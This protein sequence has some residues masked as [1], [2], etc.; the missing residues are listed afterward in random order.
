MF[1]A[2]LGLPVI[3][4]GFVLLHGGVVEQPRTKAF[5]AAGQHLDD[6]VVRRICVPFPSAGHAASSTASSTNRAAGSA[7]TGFNFSI[8][9][10]RSSTDHNFGITPRTPS[11]SSALCSFIRRS[12]ITLRVAFRA[13]SSVANRL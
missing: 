12:V 2:L 9:A 5:P 4:G 1:L 11:C 13:V 10:S 7:A 8:A 3:A 6:G